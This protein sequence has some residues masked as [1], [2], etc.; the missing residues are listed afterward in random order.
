MEKSTNFHNNKISK[1]GSQFICFSVVLI[2]SVFG[3]GKNYNPQVFLECKYIVKEKRWASVLLTTQK[4]ILI[5]I[6]KILMKKFPMKKILAYNLKYN[7]NLNVLLLTLF[8]D[9]YK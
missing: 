4:F 5:L 2:N 9:I 1:K 8:S 3:T 6:E 7:L